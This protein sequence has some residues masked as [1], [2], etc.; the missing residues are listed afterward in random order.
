MAGGKDFAGE[1]QKDFAS[2]TEWMLGFAVA[3]T[4]QYNLDDRE[5]MSKVQREHHFITL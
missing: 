4:P 3:F 5:A 2:N 1:A